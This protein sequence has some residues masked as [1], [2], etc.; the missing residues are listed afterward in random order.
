MT[1]T[2]KIK[3]LKKLMKDITKQINAIY[4]DAGTVETPVDIDLVKTAKAMF[5]EDAKVILKKKEE[6][7]E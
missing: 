2:Q 1:D 5:Y 4:E 3:A 6:E 7:T